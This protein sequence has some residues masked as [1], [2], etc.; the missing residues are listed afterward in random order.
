VEGHDSGKVVAVLNR[1]AVAD[2]DDAA[3]A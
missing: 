1:I 3:A 2:L